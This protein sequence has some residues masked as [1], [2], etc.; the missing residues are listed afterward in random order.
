MLKPHLN[1]HFLAGDLQA[2]LNTAWEAE[3]RSQFGREMC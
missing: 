2:G 1:R 3:E